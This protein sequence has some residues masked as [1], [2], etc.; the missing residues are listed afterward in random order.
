ME[1]K[2]VL[3]VAAGVCHTM[4]VTEDGS[5]FAFGLNH[6][7]QLG[8]GDRED[9]LVPTLA[10]LSGELDNKSV[11]QVAAGGAH[12]MFVTA[13]GLVFACGNNDMRQLGV[14]DTESR[15]VATL[16]TAQLQGNSAVYVAAGEYHTLCIT[17]DGSLFAWGQNKD[18]KLGVGDTEN[19]HVPTMVTGLQGKQVVHVAAGSNHTICTTTDGAVFT[20]G[21]GESWKLGL[22]DDWSNK[23]APALVRGELQNKAVIQVAAGDHHSICV[24]EDGSV[25]SWGNIYSL[26]DP[27]VQGQL[28]GGTDGMGIPARLQVLDLNENAQSA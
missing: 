18:G 13:D 28:G 21:D 25:Y 2:K 4:C 10:L 16:V 23:L 22:G 19:R 15:L 26:G 12:T 20:W 24:A 9:R 11:L 17:A 14:G 1:G 7:G 3:Q 8:M 27:D 5:A 6:R